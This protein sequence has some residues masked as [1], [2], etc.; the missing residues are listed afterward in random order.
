MIYRTNIMKIFH[1]IA[2]KIFINDTNFD[3]NIN[4][5][6]HSTFSEQTYIHHLFNNVD[7][8]IRHCAFIQIVLL[9]SNQSKFI[10]FKTR[11]INNTFL[12]HSEKDRFLSFFYKIQKTY[13]TL[14]KFIRGLQLRKFKTKIE[15]DLLLCP[16]E[17]NQQNIFKL[18]F[19]KCIYIFT[20]Q[21][22]S[23]IIISSICNSP[24]F[25]SE[26]IQPKNPYNGVHFSKA[27][28]YNIYF[29][30]K[31]KL[32]FVPISIHQFFL[33][34]FDIDTF[35]A[36]NQ[37]LIR[38]VYINQFVK[39]ESD[40][41]ISEYIYDMLSPYKKIKIDYEFPRDIL[42]DT[43]KDIVTYYLHYKYS[44]DN[45]RRQVNSHKIKK[46]INEIITKEPKFGCK[47]ITV[48]NK[49][50]YVSFYTLNGLTDK[51]IRK[52]S[53]VGYNYTIGDSDYSDSDSDSDSDS[54]SDTIIGD[55]DITYS[56]S[57]T[58]QYPTPTIHNNP[59][60]ISFN[61]TNNL[62]NTDQYATPTIHN[63]PPDIS[64]NFMNANYTG[65]IPTINNLI[66][67]FNSD[68]EL[69]SDDEIDESMFDP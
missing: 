3:I 1:Y 24:L 21:D 27:D 48:E 51:T 34:N 38:N 4:P 36:N 35:M 32:L 53:Y 68:M 59:P 30:M 56:D 46:Y 28:L 11:C 13:W 2:N 8:D 60:D 20:L 12:K 49:K 18:F 64:F 41:E 5:D 55:S 29:K 61:F 19:N 43:F 14:H 45:S 50:E 23:R 25:H 40:H 42:V 7:Y 15:N 65:T 47:I 58:V 33:S 31:E 16:I 57:D 10:H 6:N 66:V 63:N 52:R 17:P 26:P 22:L 39:N 54:N 62:F 69:D 67:E 37:L 9:F 44:L